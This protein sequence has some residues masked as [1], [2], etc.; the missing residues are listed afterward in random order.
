MT[1]VAIKLE[2]H[3]VSKVFPP[4]VGCKF[5]TLYSRTRGRLLSKIVAGAATDLIKSDLVAQSSMQPI[6]GKVLISVLSLH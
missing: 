2:L 1:I 5:V 4:C 6:S 3:T